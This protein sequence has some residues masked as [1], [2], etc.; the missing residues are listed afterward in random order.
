MYGNDSGS[1]F[2]LFDSAAYGGKDL[3]FKDSTMELKD[4]SSQTYSEFLGQAYLDDLEALDDCVKPNTAGSVKN[5]PYFVGYFVFSLVALML[6][7]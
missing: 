3:L 4:V 6:F 2:R 1:G 5:T 7:I